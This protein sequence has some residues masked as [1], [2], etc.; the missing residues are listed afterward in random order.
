[1]KI[2]CLDFDGVLHSYTS[3]WKGPRCIPDDPV[4]GAIAWLIGAIEKF[5][6]NI[7]S[8]RS[9]YFLG[10]WVMKQW[11]IAALAEYFWDH[12][13]ELPE[14]LQGQIAKDYWTAYDQHEEYR[15]AARRLVKQIK[16]PKHKPPAHIMVDDRALCFTGT[17]PDL[18]ALLNFKPW[19][20]T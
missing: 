7:F 6:I 3:G 8:S 20:K 14:Y 11:L 1:M 16:F 2:L 19:N 10:R 18:D 4:P 17:W 12:F 5:E 15:I 9:N 13:N